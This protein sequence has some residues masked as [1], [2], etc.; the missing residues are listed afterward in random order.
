M[1][2]QDAHGSSGDA[3]ESRGESRSEGV[4]EQNGR[5]R[6]E[7]GRG[8][9]AGDEREA[10]EYERVACRKARAAEPP[11][12]DGGRGGGGE[13]K[14]ESDGEGGE[15]RER[16]GGEGEGEQ[17]AGRQAVAAEPA[18][19]DRR[20]SKESEAKGEGRGASSG[21]SERESDGERA[22]EGGT[23]EA[24][25][26]RRAREQ[27]GGNE[28]SENTNGRRSEEK[29]E[30]SGMQHSCTK[31]KEGR[32]K[33][34]GG[35]DRVQHSRMRGATTVKKVTELY[36]KCVPIITPVVKS[37]STSSNTTRTLPARQA[38]PHARA[39][40]TGKSE[41]RSKQGGGGEQNGGRVSGGP[42]GVYIAGKQFDV[43]Q[44][45]RD[46]LKI[47]RKYLDVIQENRDGTPKITRTVART[48][49]RRITTTGTGA[50]RQG[51]QAQW[52]TLGIAEATAM[53]PS[54]FGGWIA[55]GRAP[56]P[57]T[58][59]SRQTAEKCMEEWG[60]R[61][62]EGDADAVICIARCAREVRNWR[63]KGKGNNTKDKVTG[64]W[65]RKPPPRITSKF[66]KKG[67]MPTA[68][69]SRAER[70]Y[71]PGK[72][73]HCDTDE[74]CRA[75][76]ITV[77]G[78]LH[79]ALEKTTKT[80]AAAML[81]AAAHV[82][83]L[84]AVIR[85]GMTRAGITPETGDV[86][87]MADLCSGVGTVA[88]AMEQETKGRWR[89]ARAAEKEKEREEVL[90]DA[91]GVRGLTEEKVQKD[92]YDVDALDAAP[93]CDV[94]A[95]TPECGPYSRQSMTNLSEAKTETKKVATMMR[96]AAR[97]RPAVVI[98]ES[99]ADLLTSTR[100]RPCGE[101]IERHLREA[102]PDYEWRKQVVDPAR[103]I[104]VPMS[105]E[106]AFWVGTRPVQ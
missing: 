91:W 75:F 92:A 21:K 51:M 104:G 74:M 26:R 1:E 22:S 43:I 62:E 37:S 102:L 85:G 19:N 96:Y 31:A 57:K 3:K 87:V 78:G 48:I 72:R 82:G 28:E 79:T 36:E 49:R 99:V 20:E 38:K 24:N 8:S 5:K 40:C 46:T 76:G 23:P 47:A 55:E 81:G 90:L 65:K 80:K 68:V 27:G 52:P 11:R 10:T 18:S 64:E 101:E 15:G 44:K 32:G 63:K 34:D 100:M 7:H 98:M 14:G 58:E 2:E 71:L 12:E 25:R 56:D 35:R 30:Q 61:V 86:V 89:Y 45:N 69:S 95:M 6:E 73:R 103:H 53:Q 33:R 93:E 97:V 84:R 70:W 41:P 17:A 42:T 9:R 59:R 77:G 66:I 39:T 88:E 13:A 50:T 60:L 67:T 4:R 94:L 106:R 83:V 16:G 54:T 29:E 105:R